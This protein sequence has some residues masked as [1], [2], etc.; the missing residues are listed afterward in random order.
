M[1]F[2]KVNLQFDDNVFLPRTPSCE[3]TSH[4]E[5]S[6]SD[7]ASHPDKGF[8]NK[9]LEGRIEVWRNRWQGKLR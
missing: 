5:L 8:G 6:D 7:M 4:Q 1:N 9:P 2:L 3:V